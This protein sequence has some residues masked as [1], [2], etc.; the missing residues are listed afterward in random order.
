MFQDNIIAYGFVN[1]ENILS[2]TIGI[3]VLGVY[4]PCLYFDE[5]VIYFIILLFNLYKLIT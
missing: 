4:F 5:S 3:R 2:S 1:F